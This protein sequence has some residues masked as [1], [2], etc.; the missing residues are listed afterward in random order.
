[1]GVA[2]PPCRAAVFLKAADLLTT[3]YRMEA[4]ATTML[5]QVSLCMCVCV[6]V[7]VCSTCVCVCVHLHV[8][9]VVVCVCV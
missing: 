2:I 6:C 9:Y 1:M 5:G 4:L 7:Y 8:Q 3:K